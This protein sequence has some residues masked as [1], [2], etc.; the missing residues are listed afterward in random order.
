SAQHYGAAMVQAR[1]DEGRFACPRT[2]YVCACRN[3]R[4]RAPYVAVAA[5]SRRAVERGEFHG[6]NSPDDALLAG[7]GNAAAFHCPGRPFRTV[8]LKAGVLLSPGTG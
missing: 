2:K 7:M 6:A 5:D 8:R 1:V 3:C 4:A